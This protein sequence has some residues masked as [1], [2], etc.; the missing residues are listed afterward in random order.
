MT[1]ADTEEDILDYMSRPKVER[2][3]AAPSSFRKGTDL[4]NDR[5][6]YEWPPKLW[7]HPDEPVEQYVSVTTVL[8]TVSGG[9]AHAQMWWIAEYVAGVTAAAKRGEKVDCWDKE[10]GCWVQRKPSEV[11]QDKHWMKAAGGRE[12]KKRAARGTVVHGVIEDWCYTWVNGGDPVDY[13]DDHEM[14]MYLGGIIESEPGDDGRGLGIQPDYCLEYARQA[15]IWCNENIERVYLAE[16]P[17]FNATYHYAGTV[18]LVCGLKG[19]PGVWL[20]DAK[21]SKDSQITHEIQQA[22]Y[23]NAELVG[24]KG[25]PPERVDFPR[26]DHVANLYIQPEK[27]TLREWSDPMDRAT[28]PKLSRAFACFCQLRLAYMFMAP[29][30]G[31]DGKNHTRRPVTVKGEKVKVSA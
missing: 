1:P 2:Q 12:L 28:G 7:R 19:R 22:A 16:A 21:S 6:I 31:E 15:I 11:L 9:I 17:I 13:T 23:A 30:V 20:V 24:I 18:D 10:S 3:A 26:V 8:D 4:R 25:P 27:A 29:T 5:G 14:E